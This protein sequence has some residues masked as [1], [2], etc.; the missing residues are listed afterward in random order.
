[1]EQMGL[2]TERWQSPKRETAFAPRH[3][4]YKR[5]IQSK[6][7]YRL[8]EV[9]KTESGASLWSKQVAGAMFLFIN[10]CKT[11]SLVFLAQENAFV[12]DFVS[13][14]AVREEMAHLFINT[15]ELVVFKN[16]IFGVN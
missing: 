9:K 13:A 6:V 4:K 1:M 11:C 2:F 8:P 5:Q 14:T 3:L 7:G 12:Q 16:T 15:N 10:K